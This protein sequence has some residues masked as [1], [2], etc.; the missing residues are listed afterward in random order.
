MLRLIA[1]KTAARGAAMSKKIVFNAENGCDC[2]NF[3]FLFIIYYHMLQVQIAAVA[4]A[5]WVQSKGLLILGIR[6]LR[7]CN[8]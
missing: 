6:G 7:F 3:I 4:T 8:V 1:C 5:D 2:S